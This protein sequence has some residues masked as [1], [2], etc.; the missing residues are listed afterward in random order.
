M[1]DGRFSLGRNDA[2]DTSVP[3]HRTP[4]IL[5]HAPMPN[6]V[7]EK[8]LSEHTSAITHKE[9]KGALILTLAGAFGIW[10]VFR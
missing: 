2:V 4:I 7:H 10:Y 3:S 6:A 5:K 9:E 8:F 1:F